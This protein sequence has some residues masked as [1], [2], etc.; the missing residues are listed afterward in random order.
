[1]AIE[2]FPADVAIGHFTQRQ[3]GG[4]VLA[5]FHQRGGARGQLAG[6][7]LDVCRQ[8]PLPP[9]HPFWSTPRLLLTAHSA[10]PTLPAP[11]VQLFLCNLQ[12]YRA[13]LPLQGEVTFSRGY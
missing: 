7:V 12:A 10:A 5:G 2:H 13:G 1:M 3:H 11:M 9:S 8:E 4:L 6:A